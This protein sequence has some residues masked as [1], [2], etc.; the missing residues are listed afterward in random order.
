MVVQVGIVGAGNMGRTHAGILREDERVRIVGVTDLLRTRAEALAD[1]VG[2]EVF[3]SVD[4]LLDAGPDA[5]LVTTPNT[6]HVPAVLAALE[7]DIH[8]FSEKPMATSLQEARQVLEAARAGKA[9]YQV[10][11]NRRFAPVYRYL[12]QQ[13]EMGF[14]PYLAN[15][16][17][18]DGDWFNPPWITDLSLTGGFLYE[19]SVH[20][21][22]MLR[23]LMGQVVSVQARA[24]ANVYDVVNDFAI[25]LAFEGHRF[26]VFS[27]SAHASWAFPFEHLE[28]VGEHAFVRSEELS[29][30]VHSPGLGQEVHIL[31][32]GQ[33]SRPDLWGYREQ[34]RLFVNACLGECPAVVGAEEAYRSI[35]LCEACYR[36]AAREGATVYLPL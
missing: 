17:Q 20:L 26:A 7:R 5:V 3:P 2:G 27:S 34:D 16:K 24:M 10:G 9:I 28:L 29:R 13:I 33:L 4:A 6:R 8:V 32:Y 31:D 23:W 19:S 21:L 12:K 25:L 11:H 18:N 30:V 1:T 35:E 36:S 15:A 22:D 14:T